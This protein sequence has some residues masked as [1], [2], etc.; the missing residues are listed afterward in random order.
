MTMVNSSNN[1]EKSQQ[2]SQNKGTSQPLGT[3]QKIWKGLKITL[4]VIGYAHLALI[5]IVAIYSIIYINFNPQRTSLMLY[6]GSYNFKAIKKTSYIPLHKVSTTFQMDLINLEDGRFREHWG[7]DIEAIQ[8]AQAL[9]EKAGYHAYGG[10][11]LTQ[12]MARTLFLIP[13]KRKKF[14]S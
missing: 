8:R 13:H 2:P 12:Q 4:K 14:L 11:T 1:S 7:F 10:S 9:N 3:K 6:R 5:F